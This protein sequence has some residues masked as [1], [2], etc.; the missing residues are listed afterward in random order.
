[1]PLKIGDLMRHARNGG[2]AAAAAVA[3][4]ALLLGSSPAYAAGWTTLSAPPTG[5]NAYLLSVS[6]DS[7]T[8]GWAVGDQETSGEYVPLVDHWNGTS[9][10][11]S[12]A[13]SYSGLSATY[14]GVS[15]SSTT[16]AW[17]V[18]YYDASRYD[19]Y[20]ITAHWN[21]T[22]WTA[23]TP[24][25][26]TTGGATVSADLL[27]VTDISTSDAYAIGE[28]VSHA[29]Q[30]MEQWNGT[31]WSTVTLP[32][33]DPSDPGLQQDLNGIS[34]DS[35]SDAWAVGT[36][37]VPLGGTSTTFQPWSVHWNG[38]S[39]TVVSMPYIS[40]SNDTILTIPR[41]VYAISP[42]NVWAVGD[43]GDLDGDGG[44]ST[45][46]VIWH[47]NGTAWSIVT[48][49]AI[50]GT[51]PVLNAV[52]GTGTSQAW[53]VG[54]YTPSGATVEQTFSLAWN[55][56]AWS[57]VSSPTVGAASMLV[58]VATTPGDIVNAVGWSESASGAYSPVALQTNG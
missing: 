44:T 15:A 20:P 23:A 29:S 45:A 58:G 53:A 9:W 48:S 55:G 39:W 31:A 38:T 19:Y 2:F 54:Y 21:G 49:P 4:L 10:A 30:I 57:V 12:T 22:S 8:D 14:D 41:A 42:T 6:T 27:G 34:A 16:D 52:T 3:A 35:A 25:Q 1:M 51:E 26:C 32:D 18:G 37:L 33:P 24:V 56:T 11:E 46:T 47:Y 5:E 13:P 7:N 28:C 17:A 40:S 50:T 36:H 43:Y